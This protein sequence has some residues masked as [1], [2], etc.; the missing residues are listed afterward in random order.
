[1]SIIEQ[2]KLEPVSLKDVTI[3]DHFWAPRR[4]INREQTIPFQYKQC[5]ETGRIDALKLNWK[6]GDPEIHPFWDS[7]VAK[8]IEAASY[9]LA[10]DPDAE[11]SKLVDEVIELISAA[12][13]EDGYLNT[14][15]TAVKPGKR[16]TDLRDAHELYCAGHFIE[17]GVAHFQATGKCS[18]LDIV[19]RYADYIDS[20]FGPEEGKIKGYP[21]HQEIELA[22]IKLYHVTGEARYFRLS[23]FFIEERGNEPHYFTEEKKKYGPGYFEELFSTFANLKEY[24]QS[25]K[26]VR[27][28]DKVVGH[29]VR[30]MYMYCAMADLAKENGDEK[31]RE[32][33]D[34]LWNNL[35]YKNMYVTGGIGST[36][37]YEGFTCDYDLPNE[38]A[39]AE[40]CAAIGL[41]FWNHRMLQL[42]CDRKYADALE[43]ALFNG[44]ISGISLDGKKYFYE[45]PLES[46][47]EVHRKEWFG[48]SC[49]P[50][51]ISRLLGSLGQYI[52]SQ[53]DSE[54]IIHL[55]VSGSAKFKLANQEIKLNQTTNYPWDG[56]VSIQLEVENPVSFA[57]K[58]R[59]PSWTKSAGLKVNGEMVSLEN[60]LDKGYVRI[61]REWKNH[62]QI[63]L[64]L[65]MTIEKVYAHPS[66]RQNRNHVALQRGPLVYCIEGIDNT[67]YLSQ[68]SLPRDKELTAIFDQK[69]LGGIVKIVGNGEITEVYDSEDL[70]QTKPFTTKSFEMT[71]VPY[72]AWDN[73]EA[74]PMK[75]WIPES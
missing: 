75:V 20:V 24:N 9:S 17:A 59:I 8:W 22:L 54:A 63:E 43:R 61:E 1:M 68:L 71:A 67:H 6:Q 32:A 14:Y 16:W 58:L 41:V 35:H 44:V 2:N 49:C 7:D 23:Q 33:C 5:K 37:E 19:C 30:A 45:N 52:Y 15:F 66:V 34:R 11:L 28:Q 4:K 70:Y 64:I 13:Q 27:E 65:P 39:Y 18:L 42:D 29:S 36:A 62:D 50:P 10:T 72:Y 31:L 53:S 48:V 46:L 38:S 3:N 69:L 47:G 57:L 74:G 73:R 56:N 26:P 25:H 12:Q 40:T 51:N 60:I 55:Y 21:G